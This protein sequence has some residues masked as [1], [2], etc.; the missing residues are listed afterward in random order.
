M[1]VFGAD[2]GPFGIGT[3]VKGAHRGALGVGPVVVGTELGPLGIGPVVL[4][5]E[6]GPLGVDRG[7]PAV[8]GLERGCSPGVDVDNDGRCS[9]AL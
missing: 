8:V 4:G 7:G 3:V 1:G 2:L 6:P 9:D 5:A